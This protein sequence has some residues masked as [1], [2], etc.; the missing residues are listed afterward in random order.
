MKH[1]HTA[2]LSVI[3]MM[4]TAAPTV[5]ETMTLDEAFDLA[6]LSAFP[7]YPAGAAKLADFGFELA[8]DGTWRTD[9]MTVN[10]AVNGSGGSTS[11]VAFDLQTDPALMVDKVIAILGAAGATNIRGERSSSGRKAELEYDL[12]GQQAGTV[13]D[14]LRLEG[15]Q[16]AI[17]SIYVRQ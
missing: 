16:G 10:P 11:C 8:S 4:A 13:I 9:T 3:L 5:A 7:D 6:C 14:P 17:I 12:A 1:L 2:Y 15:A